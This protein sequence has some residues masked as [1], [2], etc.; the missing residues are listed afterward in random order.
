MKERMDDAH[1]REA[2][3]KVRLVVTDVDGVHTPDTVSLFVV[4]ENDK[5]AFGF[6]TA[7]KT[8]RF[9]AVDADGTPLEEQHIFSSGADGRI[10][11]YRFY[12]GDGIAV[13]ECLRAEIPV[14]FITGR[15]SPAVKQRAQDLG[16]RCFQGVK[17]KV[18]TIETVLAELG[19][20]WDEVLF[21]GNDIQDLSIIQ[22]AG[23]SAAPA[24]AVPEVK[25]V[26]DY[27]ANVKGGDGAVREVLQLMLDAKGLWKEIVKRVRTLG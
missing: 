25:A 2:F 24:D 20:A 21:V 18:A 19:V 23:V 5:K 22:C 27:L 15:N 1:L 12:T 7:G 6:E 13:K 9:V 8:H 10:E 17:D 16:A 26:V 4:H 11:G 14:V 3:K